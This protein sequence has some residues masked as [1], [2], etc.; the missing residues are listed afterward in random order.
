VG[1][2]WTRYTLYG[3]HLLPLANHRLA[4]DE[5][6]RIRA[7]LDPPAPKVEHMANRFNVKL[8]AVRDPHEDEV[9][10]TYV[11]E[12]AEQE[13][14]AE[15]TGAKVP[16][17]VDFYASDSKPCDALAPRFAAVAQRYAGKVR[18]L[19]VPRLKSAALAGK[20]GVTSAPTLVFFK[21]G[22]EFGA[23]LSGDAIERTAL[24]ARVE[25]LLA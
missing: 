22:Q 10:A 25:A 6:G 24:K 12:V 21:D 20:L 18:F 15:L 4:R 2:T 7:W 14:E 19:R 8:P 16:V 9:A 3:G 17:V 11:H 1:S 13:F 23:R 5:R